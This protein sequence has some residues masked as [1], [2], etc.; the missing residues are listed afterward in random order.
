MITEDEMAFLYKLVMKSGPE[1][2]KEYPL[3]KEECVI[4]REL[5]NDLIISDPEISR[6]HARLFKKKEQYFVEDLGSTNGTFFSGKRL[7]KPVQLKNGDSIALGKSI[8]FEFI[9]EE[10]EAVPQVEETKEEPQKKQ[11]G[12][13][14][15]KKAAVKQEAPKQK[16]KAK[17]EVKPAAGSKKPALLSSEKLRKTPTWVLVIVIVLLFLLVFCLIPFLII[18]WTDQ[19]CNLLGTIF[20]QIQPGVCPF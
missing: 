10:K 6:R 13:K 11:E 19:W 9:A 14:E 18:D 4:G 7:T 16:S 5:I 8:V 2:N 1:E 17:T 15:I 12:T 20:N 3:E